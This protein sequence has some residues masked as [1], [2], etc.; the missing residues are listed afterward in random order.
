MVKA[1][2]VAG[3]LFTLDM[4]D[5]SPVWGSLVNYRP[6]E[7]V[8][9][10]GEK[11]VFS[12]KA[13][14]TLEDVPATP[15]MK[16]NADEEDMPRCD[17]SATADGW[18]VDMAP[19]LSAP[20][21][22]SILIHRGGWKAE[23][24]PAP[25]RELSRFAIDNAMMLLFAFSTATLGTLEMHASVTVKDGKGYLFLARSGTGKSTHSRMWLENIPG[26]WLL[27]DDNPVVRLFPDGSAK[28]FGSPWSGK[29]P[30]YRNESAAVGAFVRIVR[31]PENS[32]CL[33]S[34][35]EAYACIYSSSSGM[36][37]DRE[38]SDG[39]YETIAGLVMSLPSYELG[40]RPDAEAAHVCYDCVSKWKP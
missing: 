19:V 4:A 29:T 13:A 25:G 28:V 10:E 35:P 2:R 8:P 12:L 34:A 5:G 36:K 21:E 23:V 39:L 30:C 18:R 9:G 7:A 40:C 15:L 26:S 38:M 20:V 24:A 11:A 6:F 14:G 31:K 32:I 33:V 17:I 37:A 27:N 16:G 1:Y 22:F 3:H